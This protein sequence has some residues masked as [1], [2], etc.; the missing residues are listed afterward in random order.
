VTDGTV[1]RINFFRNGKK[2]NAAWNPTLGSHSTLKRFGLLVFGS[3]QQ[4]LQQRCQVF[5]Q[6]KDA[7]SPEMKK[8]LQQAAAIPTADNAADAGKFIAALD[9]VDTLSEKLRS[10]QFAER[11]SASGS[12]LVVQY[13]DPYAP[14]VPKA[15]N[16]AFAGELKADFY[17]SEVRDFAVNLT[18]T[19]WETLTVRCG[20]FAP[21]SGK[22][23]YNSRTIDY[24]YT[25]LPKFQTEFFT[26]AKA[27]AFDGTAVGDVLA[28]N[29]AGV[30]TIAPGMTQ[31]LYISVQAP[32][33][34]L[35][36]TGVL[37]IDSIDGHKFPS[38]M[39]PVD[40]TVVNSEPASELRPFAFGWDYMHEPI[41][42]DRPEYTKKHYA[43][44]K[45]YGF[46]ATLISNLRHLPRPRATADGRIPEQL[47]FSRLRKQLEL[48]GKFDYYYLDIAI[49]NQK[50][51]NRELFN[52][53][54]YHPAY[55]KAFKS[56]LK[57]I[58]AELAQHGINSSNLLL[59]PIDEAADK[60]A[61]IIAAWIKEVDPALKVIIDSS[62]DNMQQLAS[63]DKYVDVWM[64][65]M[66]TLPQEALNEFHNYIKD[67]NKTRFAYY[68]SAGGEEKIKSPYADYIL[69]FYRLYAKGFSGL[70]FWAAGQYY[71]DPWYRKAYPGVYDTSLIY[72]AL[73]G[74]IP[75]R[76][77]AA[78]R[79]GVQDLWLMRSAEAKLQ[80]DAAAIAE[81]RKAA[82]A[83][84]SFPGDPA[85]AD[86]LRK[87]CRKLLEK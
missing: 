84:A 15:G 41:I 20:L 76:R 62:T 1:W 23:Q 25:N 64:P 78:W 13:A 55:G 9:L 35:K 81:L 24:L 85:R 71:G 52:L 72:P 33:E 60:R 28:P 38:V 50:L 46:N 4:A 37:L 7:K 74:P 18:N 27:S 86:E 2:Y 53:D 83:A 42:A 48:I 21:P 75:S 39:L 43:M 69:N 45:K 77:L 16:A 5:E 30:F 10:L 44:L 79:R 49:W 61:E 19:G 12:P 82:A 68:Y 66:R 56:W 59:C 29:P 87:Y 67:Q 63:L 22:F 11:F 32:D 31:Q 6:V 51:Q 70:G 65:H 36:S 80:N 17:R 26:V 73:N 40:F 58:L 3:M 14:G 8:L 47:D 57:L 34:A 54:F